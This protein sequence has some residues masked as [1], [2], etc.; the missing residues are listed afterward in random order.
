MA[1]QQEHSYTTFF[2]KLEHFVPVTAPDGTQIEVVSFLAAAKGILL[3]I[4]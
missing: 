3:F 4:G 2:A 1:E